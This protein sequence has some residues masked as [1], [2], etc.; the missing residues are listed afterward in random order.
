MLLERQELIIYEWFPFQILHYY[1]VD[2]T[3]EIR[4]VHHANDGRDPFPV[5]I[6]RRRMQIDINDI[7]STV[8]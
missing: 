8:I 2:D 3:M 4:E 6:G 1:L 7:P 5:L